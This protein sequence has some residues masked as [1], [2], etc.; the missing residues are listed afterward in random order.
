M[1]DPVVEEDE[2]LEEEELEDEEE[3][4]DELEEELEDELE[5]EVVGQFSILKEPVQLKVAWVMVLLTPAHWRPWI[6]PL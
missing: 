5:E 3:L 4:D 1:S 6:V 2:E